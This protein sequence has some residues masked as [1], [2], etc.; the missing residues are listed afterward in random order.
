MQYKDNTSA[1]LLL[2]KEKIIFGRIKREKA[3]EIAFR[4][5][6]LMAGAEGL[7]PSARGFGGRKVSFDIHLQVEIKVACLLAFR[8]VFIIFSN[9]LKWLLMHLVC[10]KCVKS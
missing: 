10:Q 5:Q 4:S 7:E 1:G 8:D 9:S 2:K 3:S 6:K